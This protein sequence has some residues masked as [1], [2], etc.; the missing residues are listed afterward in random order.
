MQL[1]GE[2]TPSTNTQH[3]V[4]LEDRFF[5]NRNIKG[6]I[7]QHFFSSQLLEAQHWC[8]GDQK[9]SGLGLRS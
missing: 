7:P 8:P 6:V 5:N 2:Q 4:Q 3:S 9:I 1:E